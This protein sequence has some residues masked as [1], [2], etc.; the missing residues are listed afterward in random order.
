MRTSDVCSRFPSRTGSTTTYA[1]DGLIVATATG[2][3][4]YA[5]GVQPG[6]IWKPIDNLSLGLTY[7]SPQKATFDQVADFDQSG[8]SDDLDLEAPQQV[9]FGAAYHFTGIELLVEAD[10]KWINWSN[11]DGYDDFDW[12]DQWVFAI[13]AQ[14]Q[15]IQGLFLRAG[16]NYAE[17]PVNEH[18]GWVLRDWWLLEWEK[19]AILDFHRQ[20]PLEGY[21]RLTFMM[22]DRDLVA[23][24][25][26]DHTKL[27]NIIA[28]ETGAEPQVVAVQFA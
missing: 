3:T 14:W 16:Y 2:S 8:L 4:A 10:T 6:V 13:G 20:F 11:A 19:Q 15:P 27:F 12:D 18:N 1:A 9:G 7:I 22:L 26:S 21:R 17:S 24:E 5:F 25:S 28:Q 23:A